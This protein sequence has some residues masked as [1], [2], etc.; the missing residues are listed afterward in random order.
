M[1]FVLTVDQRDSR[2]HPDAV[3]AAV[4]AL[5]DLTTAGPP[6]PAPAPTQD[7]ERA[8]LPLSTRF[9][10]TVGDELQGAVSDG[11]SVVWSILTLMDQTAWHIGI[12][13]GALP[14]P[15]PISV[16]SAGGPIFW[17]AR[18]AVEQAKHDDTVVVVVAAAEDP[19][20]AGRAAEA[21]GTAQL[22]LDLVT[23][24]STSGREAVRLARAGLN[25]AEIAERLQVT[26]QAV[27]Q[28][29]AAARWPLEQR[30]VPVLASL[31]DRVDR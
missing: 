31:L 26:R 7:R 16:R 4:T 15:L 24:R 19:D 3:E 25:Q 6:G 17:A 14:D 27:G 13:V 23:R 21:T 30:A 20:A 9:E 2:H 5:D 11:L 1:S 10:R 12:G 22:L 28:R 8:S 18:S 29:L